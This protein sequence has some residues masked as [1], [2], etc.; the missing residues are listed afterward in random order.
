MVEKQPLFVVDHTQIKHPN[1]DVHFGHGHATTGIK[2]VCR[3]TSNGRIVQLL[4]RS[5]VLAHDVLR[6]RVFDS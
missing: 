1:A 5:F 3:R 4:E 2:K 6:M